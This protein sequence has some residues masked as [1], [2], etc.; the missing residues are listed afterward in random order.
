[1]SDEQFFIKEIVKELNLDLN[2]FIELEKVIFQYLFIT[3]NFNW[4][5]L[6]NEYHSTFQKYLDIINTKKFIKNKIIKY[7]KKI[8]YNK[9]RKS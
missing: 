9:K 8:Y 7:Y 4:N 5:N 1:M 3:N 2:Q 6:Y